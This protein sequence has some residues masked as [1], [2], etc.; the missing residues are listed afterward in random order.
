MRTEAVEEIVEEIKPEEV[1]WVPSLK[2]KHLKE[3]KDFPEWSKSLIK[4]KEM[5]DN[6][7]QLFEKSEGLDF[8]IQRREN[9]ENKLAELQTTYDTQSKEVGSL[10]KEVNTFNQGI[11]SEDIAEQRYALNN[12]AKFSDEK[13]LNVARHILEMQKLSPQQ[14]S[15]QNQR[16]E[17]KHQIS[18]YEQKLQDLQSQVN[19]SQQMAIE[20]QLDGFLANR[21]D[22]VKEY[23]SMEG[24]EG[25][26]FK[27]DFIS[28]GIAKEEKLGKP[29]EWKDTFKEFKR[30]HGLGKP[31]VS[32]TTV[33]RKVPNLSST[34]Q[35]PIE[36]NIASMDEFE[37]IY[38]GLNS[39]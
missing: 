5:E 9:L 24:N 4:S 25:S 15:I 27:E 30:I 31:K 20:S 17:T 22:A 21:S 32:P 18:D 1:E 11:N 34:G 8:S 35:S 37:K 6:F 10:V 23:E 3:E 7:K 38:N 36:K 26:S 28:Y 14:Q 16:F 19:T 33:N 13:I 29:L 39:Y 12:S 2:Y